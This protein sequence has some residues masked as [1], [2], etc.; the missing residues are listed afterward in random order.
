MVAYCEGSCSTKKVIV[1]CD[2]DIVLKMAAFDLLDAVFDVLQVDSGSVYLLQSAKY[3]FRK[4][5]S[6]RT[7]YGDSGVKRAVAFADGAQV[8]D[9]QPQPQDLAALSD[10]P[11]MDPG[12]VTLVA[13]TAG[14]ADFL[15]LSGDKRW[16]IA[17]QNSDL[18]HLRERLSNRVLTT[19]QLLLLLYRV[20]G[21]HWLCERV[22]PNRD[23]D[24]GVSFVFTDHN[25]TRPAEI[26]QGL[27]SY[28]EDISQETCLACQTDFLE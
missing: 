25:S 26:L 2:N 17:L 8:P 19:E 4:N 1:L 12:E 13:L 22:T 18:Q 15:I 3:Y 21:H 20:N 24:L 5:A 27:Q 9:W 28:V 10:I 7:K 16:M 14:I 6:L 23:C 11:D